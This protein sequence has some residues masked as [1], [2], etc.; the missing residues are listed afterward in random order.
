MRNSDQLKIIDEKLKIQ[1]RVIFDMRRRLDE[2][3]AMVEYLKNDN[4]A[5]RKSLSYYDDD[6]DGVIYKKYNHKTGR[7]E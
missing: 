3:S 4:F 7:I 6:T 1:D 2:L 5:L